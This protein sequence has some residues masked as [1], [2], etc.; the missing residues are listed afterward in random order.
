MRQ[1]GPMEVIGLTSTDDSDRQDRAHEAGERDAGAPEAAGPPPGL[2]DESRL[3]P[4]ERALWHEMWS[5]P[6]G[7]EGPAIRLWSFGYICMLDFG[8]VPK[9]VSERLSE[10]DP[11]NLILKYQENVRRARERGE[12]Q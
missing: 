5:E 2:L 10:L 3:R 9:V 11:D 8:G 1:P 12:L 7:E 6:L 4:E